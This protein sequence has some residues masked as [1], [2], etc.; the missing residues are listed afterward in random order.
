[1]ANIKLMFRTKVKNILHLHSYLILN[2]ILVLNSAVL[3][4][5]CFPY[6][7]LFYDHTPILSFNAMLSN[8]CVS[9][10]SNYTTCTTPP[11]LQYMT[12]IFL[13]Y[14]LYELRR[15]DRGGERREEER[16]RE[17]KS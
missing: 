10:V 9:A 7:V 15:L 5:L 8:S 13:E 17:E 14:V 6:R 2:L 11:A 3:K 4:F 1:M 16:R 12:F